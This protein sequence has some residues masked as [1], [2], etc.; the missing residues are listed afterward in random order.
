MLCKFAEEHCQSLP[1]F[2]WHR[3]L[4]TQSATVQTEQVGIIVQVSHTYGSS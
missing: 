3:A 1:N 2:V 4:A